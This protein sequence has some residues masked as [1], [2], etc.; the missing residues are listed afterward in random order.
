MVRPGFSS[1]GWRGVDG[2]SRP[3]Q[4]DVRMQSQRFARLP[5]RSTPDL[6][7]AFVRVRLLAK[8]R[9]DV[10]VRHE[11]MEGARITRVPMTR[12]GAEWAWRPRRPLAPQRTV[13]WKPATSCRQR[14]HPTED[15]TRLY[16]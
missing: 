6:V 16:A 14:P 1:C 5:D 12:T 4:S 8:E 3:T 2:R 15:Q 9:A 11:R 7:V 10:V 13:Q